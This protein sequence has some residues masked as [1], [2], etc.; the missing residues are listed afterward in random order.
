MKYIDEF[1]NK[2]ICMSLAKEIFR[3][4]KG[5]DI[6]LMEVCGTH[7]MAI[8]RYGIKGL[9]PSN[10]RLL[11]GPGCPVCVTPDAEID[12]VIAYARKRGVI[13][14]T[15]GDMMRVPG[16]TS[17]LD[18]EKSQGKDIRIVYSPAD[19]LKIARKNPEKTVIFLGIGFETTSPTVSASINDAKDRGLDNY[20]V[21]CKHKMIP[22]AIKT[23]LDC[24]E[25]LI[26]GFLLPGHVA[27][28]TGTEVYEFIPEEYGISCVVSGFEPV[29]IL[30]A[31]L[32]LAKQIKAG[33]PGVENQY[34]RSVKKKGNQKAKLLLKEVFES[35]DCEWRG[36]GIIPESG[37]RIRDKYSAFDADSIPVEVEPSR[38]NR[39]CI[40]GEI[41]RGVKTPLNCGLFARE[42]TPENPIGP[43]MV[44]SEGTC[45]AYYKYGR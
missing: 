28:I 9:I 13:I 29:D 10:I 35:V 19:A 12:K 2:K 8:Y 33:N 24:G 16:S 17:S 43:C 27:T 41:L 20:F 23:L 6:T 42:C 18:R 37:L 30:Q 34:T 44:S 21:L 25:I 36:L 7:T 38:K 14:T 32:M 26:D 39:E 45:A 11:S 4:A 3:I 15:F 22:P 5:R 1:R 40:C 31:I